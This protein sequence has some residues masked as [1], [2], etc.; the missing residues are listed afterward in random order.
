M[1]SDPSTAGPAG[2]TG[3]YRF[4]D[5][6]VDAGAHTV[7]RAGDA[8]AL[9]PKAFAVLL[10][11]LARPGALVTRDELL[12][13]VWGHRHVTP[14]VLTRAIAQLRTALGDD[15]HHPRYIRT[16]HALGYGF[17]GTLVPEA[18]EVPEAPATVATERRKVPAA[19]PAA[20]ARRRPPARSLARP[21]MGVVLVL[22]AFVWWSASTREPPVPAEASVAVLPF[23]TLGG[24]D[25]D[26]WFAEGLALEMLDALAGIDGITVAA[27][28]P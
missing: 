12:D 5:V 10:E 3:L 7:H 24:A 17:I 22:A 1:T 18:P 19:P 25:D 11:L 16:Q 27:W 2:R 15:P 9:E 28:R 26:R 8:Q 6:V 14:G 21:L 23:A 20:E 4:G 13:A